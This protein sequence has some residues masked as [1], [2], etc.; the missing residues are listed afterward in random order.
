MMIEAGN[1]QLG[2][3]VEVIWEP[4]R[5]KSKLF[6][7]ISEA[8]S[9]LCLSFYI[10]ENDKFGSEVI[11]ALKA[12]ARQGVLVE[13]L[14]DGFGSLNFIE[15]LKKIEGCSV[16]VYHPLPW[17]FSG[18]WFQWFKFGPKLLWFLWNV[19]IRNHQKMLIADDSAAVIGS[20]NIHSETLEWHETSLVLSDQSDIKQL[21]LIFDWTWSRSHSKFF[22]NLKG[23]LT[24]GAKL[25]CKR[26]FSNH[27]REL[28]K[29]KALM[30]D[31]LL[32]DAKRRI[33]IVTPYFLPS[34]N[35]LK[36]MISAKIRGVSVEV[37]LPSLSDVPFT[38]KIAQYYYSRL[39]SNQ[40]KVYELNDKVLHAK[41]MIVDDYILVGSSNFNNRS[42]IRDLEIDYL[43]S[44]P[45]TEKTFN[46]G[47]LRDLN[48]STEIKVQPKLKLLDLFLVKFSL[49][50]FRSWF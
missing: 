44:E 29:L 27:T 10:F 40:I 36:A 41:Y 48:Q 28:R 3:P 20:R 1:S 31:S 18:H 23:R 32:K 42:R 43:C 47:F 24:P 9:K 46:Q 8:K 34:K 39:L 49:F 50:F 21:Q 14:I 12:K 37:L 30:I 16:R 22:K 19:N 17:P 38:K 5:F 13:L 25:D 33:T 15:S 11:E 7:I 2:G 4:K 45:Q 35:D 26:L 6:E